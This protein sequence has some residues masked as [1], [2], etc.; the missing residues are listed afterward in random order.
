MNDYDECRVD[1]PQIMVV[2]DTPASL[3]LMTE[4]LA[5]HGYQVR[6]A[7]SGRLALRSMA[8]EAPNLIL[9]DVM[10]PDMDG[11]EVCRRLKSDEKCCGF[12]VIFISALDEAVDKIRGFEAGGVDYIT[13]PFQAAEVLARVE[14]HLTLQRLYKQL[15]TRNIQLQQEISDRRK[16]EE[17]LRESEEK[18][19]RFFS[20]SRDCVFITSRDGCWIDLNDAAIELFGYASREELMQVRI[21]D[22][23]TN[24]EERAKHISTIEACGYTKECPVDLLRKDGTVINSLITTVARYDTEG[25]VIGFQGTIRDITERKKAEE[26]IC[27]LNEE[28][29]QKVEERTEQLLAAQEELIRKGKL[30]I[31]GQLAGI[32]GHELRNPLGVMSNAIYYLQMVLTEADDTTREYLDIIKKEIGNSLRIITDLLDF[33]RTKTTQTTTVAVREL[34]DGSLEKCTIPKSVAVQLDIPDPSL[35]VSVDLFQMMQVFEN[36]I[37]NA[38][39]AMPA[40]GDLRISA[41]HIQ[42]STLEAQGSKGNKD[43]HQTSDIRPAPDFVEISIKDTGEGISPENMEK[44]FQPLFTTK[45]K[46]I[47]LGLVVC[48]NL[49]EANGGRIEVQSRLGRGTSFILTLPIKVLGFND[50]CINR[51]QE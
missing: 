47:G 36:L 40:G 18:Y 24:H 51:A 34:I 49:T 38:A 48:K 39:Q 17:A 3:N 19:R 8:I 27:K 42:G 35:V 16:T 22:L 45:T 29:E 50:T 15:E 20:T 44:L 6:S 9:L 37:T 32:V 23:Y 28:L 21:S 46:G 12:P 33:A 14:M 7:R 11:Y 13:K 26:K 43:E 5:K 4:I 10:M 30:S 41:R 1:A 25:N 2:D 31:L